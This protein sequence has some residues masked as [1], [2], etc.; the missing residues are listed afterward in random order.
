MVLMALSE[1][2]GRSRWVSLAVGRGSQERLQGTQEEQDWGCVV[3]NDCTQWVSM[4]C[5]YLKT[6]NGS[7]PVSIRI[8][9]ANVCKWM[10]N[11][12]EPMLNCMVWIL[13]W[14]TAMDHHITE[15]GIKCG[16]TRLFN[17]LCA[18]NCGSLKGKSDFKRLQKLKSK[19]QV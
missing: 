19:E 1:K 7:I 9:I 15:E 5:C 2:K 17:R 4:I 8:P 16:R 3:P 12:P 6:N 11:E 14:K 13:Q 18:Q 10:L